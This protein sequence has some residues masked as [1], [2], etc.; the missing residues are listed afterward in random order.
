MAP[1]AFEGIFFFAYQ[2]ATMKSAQRA[3]LSQPHL[4]VS[5]NNS[6]LSFTF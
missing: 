5:G 3:R 4:P 1:K 6:L 2:K